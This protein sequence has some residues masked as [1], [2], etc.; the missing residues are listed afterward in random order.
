[1]QR[2]QELEQIRRELDALP[3]GTTLP[4]EEIRS[5]I[6]RI[7]IKMP[8][9]WTSAHIIRELRGPLPEDDPLFLNGD[10]R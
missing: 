9:G 2:E 8:P 7:G 5:Y 10:R 4:W 3:E 1:M 6:R